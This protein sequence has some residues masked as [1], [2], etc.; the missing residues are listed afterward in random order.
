MRAVGQ[1]RRGVIPSSSMSSTDSLPTDLA[2]AHAL[3]LAQ[4][5]ALS[6][7]ETKAR[8]AE[9]E[10]RARELLIEQMKFTIAKLQHEQFGQSEPAPEICTRR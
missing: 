7:A 10:V 6:A 8:N 5:Q 9:A 4:R 1:V 3:I 2:G